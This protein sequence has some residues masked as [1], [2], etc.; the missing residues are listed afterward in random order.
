MAALCRSYDSHAEALGAVHSVLDAG[1]PGEDVRVLTGEAPHDTREETVGEFA[2]PTGPDAPVGQFA[3]GSHPQAQEGGHFAGGE[4]RGGSFADADREEVISYPG[5]VEHARVVGHRKVKELLTD[6][7]L[8][9]DTAERD[10]EALHAGRVLVL[11]K[12]AEDDAERVGELL[13]A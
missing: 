7:G 4:Q 5:G 2:G 1:I 10:V 11:V 8:D 9:A 3:G 12:A 13:K 6:A